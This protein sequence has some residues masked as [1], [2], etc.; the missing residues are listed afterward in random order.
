[1]TISSEDT[2]V[3]APD[4]TLVLDAEPREGT[5]PEPLVVSDDPEPEVPTGVVEEVGPPLLEEAI[6]EE[7]LLTWLLFGNGIDTVK[8]LSLGS[9]ARGN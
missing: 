6:G 2:G 3:R 1:M 9:T 5:D 7:T 4:E 8:L